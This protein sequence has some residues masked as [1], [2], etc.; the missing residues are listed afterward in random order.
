MD[1]SLHTEYAHGGQKREFNNPLFNQLSILKEASFKGIPCLWYDARWSEQFFQFIEILIGEN[2]PPKIIEI[3]PP[4]MDYCA[5][6][7]IFLDK[8][9]IFEKK[10]TNKYPGTIIAIENRTASYYKRDKFL[11]SNDYDIQKLLQKIMRDKYKLKLMLDIP[12]LFTALGGIEQLNMAQLSNTFKKFE[13]EKELIIGIHIWGRAG[14]A[15]SGNLD[16]LFNKDSEFKEDFL[17][18][19]SEYFDDGIPRYL[20]PEVNFSPQEDFDSIIGDLLK[21]FEFV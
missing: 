12:Q 19:I 20:V 9:S 17:R 1:Y 18:F 8:Y 5:N 14:R 2:R 6:L 21:Y 11:I 13:K 10:I 3:H 16:S 4:F 7:D 15:H